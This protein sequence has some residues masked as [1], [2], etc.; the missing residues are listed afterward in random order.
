MTMRVP[1]VDL[2]VQ[3]AALADEIGDAVERVLRSSRFVLGPEVERFERAAADFLGARYAV[4]V[5]SGTDALLVAL[6]SIGVGPG[7]EVLTTPFS[8][9]ATVEAILRTGAQPH[10]VDIDPRTLNIDETRVAAAIADRTRAIVPVHL[11]GS[12]VRLDTLRDVAERRG[13]PIVEDAAQSFGARYAS[14]AAGTWGRLGCFSF[15]PAKV[16]GAIGDGGLIVTDDERLA[17]RC[18]RLRAHGRERGGEHVEIGGNFRLDAVHAAVLSV[19]LGLVEG[20]IRARRA[21]A[22]V[23]DAAL[24]D[25]TGLA[26]VERGEGWNGAVYTVRVVEGRRDACRAHLAAAGVETAVYYER[27]LH[28]QPALSHLG[29]KAGSFPESERAALEVLSL[30]VFPEMSGQQRDHVVETV[31]GFFR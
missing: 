24:G 5:S 26:P 17:A 21:H 15:F 7:D 1:F 19:K 2:A 31:K 11:Y 27:P 13:V 14:R 6:T 28:L 25:L 12:P 4:G 9:F 20:W 3:H 29:L 18:R 23:Y 10:F 8:F 30:P 22:A 16:L